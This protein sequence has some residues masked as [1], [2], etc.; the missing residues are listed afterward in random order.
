MSC[1]FR[2]VTINVSLIVKSVPS[3][4]ASWVCTLV[5]V[6]S[7]R[8]VSSVEVSWEDVSN[9]ECW[10]SISSVLSGRSLPSRVTHT[11]SIHYACQTLSGSLN[12]KCQPR[13]QAGRSDMET[14]TCLWTQPARAEVTVTVSRTGHWWPLITG[15]IYN[16]MTRSP[17][18]AFSK[19]KEGQLQNK[20]HA[21]LY[22]QSDVN[23]TEFVITSN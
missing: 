19:L 18:C 13:R 5:D 11:Y 10:T 14:E 8:L 20:W 3:L 21:P 17:L 2:I 4:T 1:G 12:V 9:S 22:P 23:I 16:L 15:R 6:E 7:G